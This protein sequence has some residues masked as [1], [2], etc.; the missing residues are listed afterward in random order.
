MNSLSREP[1]LKEVVAAWATLQKFCEL[2]AAA[3]ITAHC[4]AVSPELA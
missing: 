4:P 3:L 2:A 1:I